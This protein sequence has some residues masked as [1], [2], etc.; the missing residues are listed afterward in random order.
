MRTSQNLIDLRKDIAR[1]KAETS[2]RLDMIEHLLN[3]HIRLNYT[4][5]MVEFMAQQTAGMISSLDCPKDKNAEDECK[6]WLTSLQS[7]YTDSLKKGK[8]IE[9]SKL[10]SQ[11][12]VEVRNY[13]KSATDKNDRTCV[14][15]M[16]KVKKTLEIN[17]S[18]IQDLGLLSSPFPEVQ[19]ELEIVT[20][21]N[22]S[23]LKTEVLDP[24]AHV[25]RL[26]IMLSV[27]G[28]NRRFTD[29]AQCTALNGGHLLYHVKRLVQ[30]GLITKNSANEYQLTVK[31]VR[32]LALLTQLG[33]EK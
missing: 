33:R 1:F 17:N 21:L 13:E 8:I 18:L 16:N 11:S 19:K 26:K 10:L 6:N 3:K 14:A 32:V 23:K 12:L 22:P 29:F 20:S 27:F 25:V 4:R 9:S 24:I 7:P 5:L 28:G 31:G 15:C 30:N 2:Q